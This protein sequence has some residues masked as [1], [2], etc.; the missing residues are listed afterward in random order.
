MVGR[1]SGLL[2]LLIT[3]G[4]LLLV[5]VSMTATP[6]LDPIGR[7]R[8]DE[9]AAIL[10][11]GSNDK[12]AVTST[13][14]SLPDYMW[15]IDAKDGEIVDL[16]PLV[17]S[18]ATIVPGVLNN[19]GIRIRVGEMDIP[20]D[21]NIQ[22]DTDSAGNPLKITL[23]DS[24]ERPVG[25]WRNTSGRAD[26]TLVGGLY[27]MVVST[28]KC[29]GEN[30]RL[31]AQAIATNEQSNFTLTN[32]SGIPTLGIQMS[33]A[34]YQSWDTQRAS[35]L[36]GL[37]TQ[38]TIE[39][40]D[41]KR[42]LAD[43]VTK[44]GR[45]TTQLWDAGLG[46]PIHFSSDTPSF[47]GKIISGPLLFGMSQ[48]KLYSIR[49]QEGLLNYVIWSILYDEGIF[50]PRYVLVRASL[51]GRSLGLYLLVETPKSQGFF[52][53]DMRYDGQITGMDTLD[54]D[55]EPA[56]GMVKQTPITI[57][58]EYSVELA[59]RVNEV[60]FAKA[61]AL[62][63]RF[64]AAHSTQAS[65]FRLYRNPYLDSLEPIIRDSNANVLNNELTM[66]AQ[67]SWW[68]GFRLPGSGPLF[69]PK[70]YPSGTPLSPY[71][72]TPTS[73]PFGS[74]YPSINQFLRLPRNREI[75]DQ[76]IMYAS[77]EAFQLRFVSRI[78]STF[79]SVALFLSKEKVPV[80]PGGAQP[81]QDFASELAWVKDGVDAVISGRAIVSRTVPSLVDK[82]VLLI[83][84]KLPET[85]KYLGNQIVSLYNLS[86]FSARL[87]LPNYVYIVTNSTATT[88]GNDDAGWYLAPS[89]L[90]PAVV[91]ILGTEPRLDL[92]QEAAQR[93][94]GLERLRFQPQHDATTTLV[95]F[96]DVIVPNDRLNDFILWLGKN[97]MVTLGSTYPLPAYRHI[98][99][100]ELPVQSE[101]LPIAADYKVS[102][103]DIVIL[104]LGLESIT[105]GYRLSLL[106]SNFSPQEISLNLSM[107]R[108]AMEGLEVEMPY[109]IHAIWKLD[110]EPARVESSRVTIGAARFREESFGSL[111]GSPMLWTG[112][113]QALIA[114]PVDETMPSCLLVE[115][116]LNAGGNQWIYTDISGLAKSASASGSQRTV[117]V[118]EPYNVYL[119]Q[120]PK[121]PQIKGYD[122][123][124]ISVKVSVSSFN[125]PYE[126]KD[127]LIDN[128]SS[129]YWHVEYP[130]KS[131]THWITLD[132]GESLCIDG[133]AIL[134]RTNSIDQLWD[135]DH[136]IFQGSNNPNGDADWTSIARLFVDKA[137]QETAGK[138]WLRYTIPNTTTYRYYRILIDDQSFLSMAEIKFKVKEWAK[139]TVQFTLTE[140]VEQGVLEI[141]STKTIRFRNKDAIISGIITIPTGYMLEF[142]AG[143]N[144]RFTDNAGILSYSPIH[145][146]GTAEQRITFL[147]A[148]GSKNWHGIAVVNAAGTNEFRYVKMSKAAAGVFGNT[149][150]T[151]GLTF[152]NS[153]VEIKDS[154]FLNFTSTDGLHLAYTNFTIDGLLMTNS[155]GDTIDSDW[156]RGTINNLHVINSG[157]DGVDVSGTNLVI[158]NSLIEGSA[159]KGVSV[160]E[161]S[162]VT[163]SKCRLLRGGKGIA[164]KDQSIV[165]VFDTEISGNQWGA[166]QYI[167]KPIY[168]YPDLQLVNCNIHDNKTNIYREKS[169]V[170]TRQFDQGN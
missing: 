150:F 41:F 55:P 69:N 131:H 113:L 146:V 114:E 163:V 124:P 160:G 123:P 11:G 16:K 78:Q 97:S 158:T 115:F 45:S 137:A 81:Y 75:F 60:A 64:Q 88:L 77:N 35:L 65:D 27:K 63:S 145:A 153:V 121:I 25:Y 161:N 83:N 9:T 48:F 37:E 30:F 74:V 119:P 2:R 82:S 166:L 42:V 8:I 10:Q 21:I 140:M 100:D 130:L 141:D 17:S 84:I 44:D 70:I 169:D 85:P 1:H 12:I 127:S 23:F 162:V 93:L 6:F 135:Q 103:P 106:I 152:M 29:L 33:K 98:L 34:M 76:Y 108:W 136:A 52:A 96:V 5:I 138:G 159:D 92:T 95:P 7:Q 51:N 116:D 107:L 40:A 156:G 144:L 118:H 87:K 71:T 13:P 134:P 68:L 90:F 109:S 122:S 79:D 91:P 54:A 32:N 149:Q 170:V 157:G 164:A 112:A 58:G 89:L 15:D 148:E 56:V 3:I 167:K 61:L 142:E 126:G 125:Q 86:P 168:I 110:Q 117:I 72:V 155:F 57:T 39:T 22:W 14:F 26:V 154:E 128:K 132:F 4:F 102:P 28:E 94:L 24:M 139:P 111:L 129:T 53:G 49:A 104:P 73:I 46:D 43:L 120:N 59:S 31:T 38:D 19:S 165:K 20:Y 99:V 18:V 62:I 105:A 101:K 47:T 147:P 133:L 36:K 151:G 67:T 50:V 80:L 66:L 143:S